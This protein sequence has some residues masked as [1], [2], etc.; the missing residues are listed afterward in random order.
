[1]TRAKWMLNLILAGVVVAATTSPAWAMGSLVNSVPSK[2]PVM[3]QGVVETVHGEWAT[4]QTPPLRPYCPPGTPCS[5]L[6]I[7]GATYE[8]NVAHASYEGP[9]GFPTVGKIKAGQQVVIAGMAPTRRAPG[10]PGRGSVRTG[11]LLTMTAD[12]IETVARPTVAPS[13]KAGSAGA[14]GVH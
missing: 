5:M 13:H 10:E 1:M 12:I 3:I 11:M 4:V 6:I 14:S 9:G 8:V 2:R 7:D